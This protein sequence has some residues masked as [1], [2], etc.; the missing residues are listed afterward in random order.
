MKRILLLVCIK[1]IILIPQSFAQKIEIKPIAADTMKKFKTSGTQVL[2]NIQFADKNGI[3]YII[4]TLEEAT[5]DDYTFKTLWIEQFIENKEKDPK[6]LQEI[7]DYEKDCPVDN[8]LGLIE[9]AFEVTDLDGN[10]FAEIFFMYK[11]GC[12]R[13]VN[14]SGLKL[15]VLQNGSKATIRG[16]TII[17]GFNE[18][19]VKQPD[20]AFKQL[21]GVIQQHANALWIKF[22]K[23]YE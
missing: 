4:A 10:G 8:Q 22:E 18:P 21:S 14:P 13:D 16:R 1:V 23:E 5:K 12:T 17:K 11:T 2:K 7:I 19:Y 3:N 9:D 20:A 15:L 6:L